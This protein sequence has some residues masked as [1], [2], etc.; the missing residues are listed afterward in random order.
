MSL[1]TAASTIPG[2]VAVLLLLG[3]ADGRPA[4][5][6]GRLAVEGGSIFYRVIGSG[7]GVPVVLIHGGPGYSSHYLE[8]LGA[9]GDDRP[10]IA[11]D[12]LG[13]GRSDRVTDTTLFAIERYA[14]E[15]DSLRRALRLKRVHL[16]GHSYGT[17]LALE[18]LR[19]EP[20]GVVSVVFSN[21][22]ISVESYAEDVRA[23]LD[24]L[25]D[26]MG[27]VILE[28][29]A[30]GTTAS[31]EYQEASAYYA[32]HHFVGM[33]PPYPAAGDSTMASFNPLVFRTMWGASDFLPVTGN[34]R[35][36]DRSLVL[37][38]LDIPVLFVAGRHDEARPETVER[39]ARLA[40]K[41]ELRILERSAHMPMFTEP[42]SYLDVIRDFLRRTER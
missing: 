13:S 28:H 42:E 32:E 20:D 25:P 22:V 9:L 10:V 38:G 41:G 21:P 30:A 3:C 40:R 39:F 33:A 24:A 6:D 4:P 15:L 27:A 7:A 14:R 19:T 34:L 35:G 18:Y 26:S 16:V 36:L 31:G 29:A 17:L 12:Q 2:L 23:T 8:G 11:Y 37:A 1:R 5:G